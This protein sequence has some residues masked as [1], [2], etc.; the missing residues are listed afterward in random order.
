MPLACLDL[1]MRASDRQS[2]GAGKDSHGRALRIE[3]QARL[4]LPGS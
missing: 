1:D 4:A 2:V 3:A